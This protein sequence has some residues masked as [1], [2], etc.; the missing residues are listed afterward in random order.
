MDIDRYMVNLFFE[1]KRNIPLSQQT[2]MKISNPDLGNV[3][4]NLYKSSQDDNIKLLTK[5]FLERAGGEW[6]KKT[7]PKHSFYRGQKVN[8]STSDSTSNETP[9]INI[10]KKST[11]KTKHQR[12]Y[13]GRVVED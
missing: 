4:V 10:K 7:Q 13:R 9:P 11:S 2:G 5:V 1:I 8:R 6:L 12:I 3:M